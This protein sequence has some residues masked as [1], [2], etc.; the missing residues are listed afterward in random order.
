MSLYRKITWWWFGKHGWSSWWRRQWPACQR[1]TKTFSFC[2]LLIAPVS[3]SQEEKGNKKRKAIFP[4]SSTKKWHMT[5]I[6]ITYFLFHFFAN[7][8]AEFNS[9]Y[10]QE[11]NVLA[12]L[13]HILYSFDIKDK[14]LLAFYLALADEH[15]KRIQLS[16]KYYFILLRGKGKLFWLASS[17]SPFKKRIAF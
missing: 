6:G 12:L 11:K 16:K 1:Y 14:L 4:N 2:S 17:F 5:F 9:L 7:D 10:L 3:F 13:L 15:N 8:K